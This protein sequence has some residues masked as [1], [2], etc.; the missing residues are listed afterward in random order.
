LYGADALA[1]VVA[2]G[3]RVFLLLY[4]DR[5]AEM[6]EEGKRRQ[7]RQQLIWIAPDLGEAAILI[8]PS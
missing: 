2:T 8:N 4:R 1:T 6:L 3:K 5:L 7:W